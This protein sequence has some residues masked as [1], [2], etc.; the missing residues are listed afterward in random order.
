MNNRRTILKT[1]AGVAASLSVSG[2]AAA[3]TKNKSTGALA[4][5]LPPPI[6]NAERRARIERAQA[7]MQNQ[8]VAGIVF[9]AGT[10]MLYFTG[11]PWRQ[12]SRVTAVVIP[13]EGAPAIVTPAFEESKLRELMVMEM[14]VRTWHEHESPYRLISGVL[15]SRGVKGGIGLERTVRFFVADGLKQ[16]APKWGLVSASSIVSA[17]RRIKSAREI[18]LMQVA[19][20]ITMAAYRE[21]YPQIQDGMTGPEIS[22]L[23]TAAMAARGAQPVFALA[24]VGEASAY[25]HGSKKVH[26]VR[27][28][29]VILMDCGCDVHGY[30]SDISRTWVHGEPDDLQRRVWRTAR[31]GQE[32]VMETARLGTPIGEIDD[33][34]RNY[35]ESEGWG[36]DY[37]LPGLSHRTGH[38]IGMD[39]HEEVFVVRGNETPLAPG[40][41]FSN[42]PGIYLPGQFGVRSED[43]VY[44]SEDGPKL[45]SGLSPSI[46]DPMG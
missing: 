30:K 12:S 20:D 13:A 11:L 14:E 36:P 21:I 19:N 8:G 1:I 42:E 18:E 31:R 10:S 25:P 43:C 34:V 44:M 40:M 33:A 6:T 24:L 38:G 28:G 29:Q 3:S 41:C 5:A 46:E 37:A 22:N 45:F 27:E 9:E 17:L 39:V 35:Y 16:D 4:S 23:M 15:D 2:G 7:L 32:I 26:V